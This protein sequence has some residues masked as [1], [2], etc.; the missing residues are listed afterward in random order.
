MASQVSVGPIFAGGIGLRCLGDDLA[1][2]QAVYR[3]AN[4]NQVLSLTFG[5]LAT[6]Q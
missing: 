2:F 1:T 4:S 6:L 3:D 5:I